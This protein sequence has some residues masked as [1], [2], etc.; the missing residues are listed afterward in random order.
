MGLNRF[1]VYYTPRPGALAD[2]GAAWLGWDVASGRSVAHPRLANLPLPVA[3]ITAAPHK[4][5]F[6]GTIKPPFRVAEA[7][8]LTTLQEA[9]K[10][11]CKDLRPVQA[12][13][14]NLSQLGRF[15]ALTVRN[16]PK[17]LLTLASRA[18]TELDPVRVPASA[19]DVA[20]RR[21]ANLSPRQD[22]LLIAWGYPYVLDEFHFHLTLTGQLT[23]EQ[24]IAV[25]STLEPILNGMPLT[26]FC[27]DALSLV[28]ED[29]DGRF[30]EISRFA[31]SG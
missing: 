26:P 7:Q 17:A 28:G 12:E 16:P 20:R 19:N 5:G 11:L 25:Q 2:F 14:L 15:L 6:H 4:Y 8:T 29:D 31:L 3:E 24:I 9:L 10:T 27:L 30:H 18:V 22:A 23:K 1:A 13:G 21:R